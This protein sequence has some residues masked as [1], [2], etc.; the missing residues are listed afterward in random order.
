MKRIFKRPGLYET[1]RFHFLRSVLWRKIIELVAADPHSMFFPVGMEIEHD[2][3]GAYSSLILITEASGKSTNWRQ[4]NKK[5]RSYLEI[6]YH[7]WSRKISFHESQRGRNY[8]FFWKDVGKLKWEEELREFAAKHNDEEIAAD[9]LKSL[10][11][12]K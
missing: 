1:E 11:W 6:R 12:K 9:L 8:H 7:S 2:P 3:N 4:D 10:S 5:P